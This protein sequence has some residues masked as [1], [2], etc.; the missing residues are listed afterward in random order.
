VRAVTG[1]P[2]VE[3]LDTILSLVV[4]P[5]GAILALVGMY[6]FAPYL[7]RIHVYDSASPI[8]RILYVL[9]VLLW[10]VVTLVQLLL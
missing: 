5:A 9:F 7:A 2:V 3:T 10:I 4:V 1:P 8:E 6:Y